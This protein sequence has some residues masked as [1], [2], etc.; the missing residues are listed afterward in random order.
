MLRCP[1]ISASTNTLTPFWLSVVNQV[2]LPLC[3]VAPAI[4]ARA[5]KRCR[6][7]VAVFARPLLTAAFQT[8]AVYGDNPCAFFAYLRNPPNKAF[9]QN[10][11]VYRTEEPIERVVG[12]YPFGQLEKPFQP[13]VSYVPEFFNVIPWFRTANNGRQSYHDNVDKLVIPR[14]FHSRVGNIR[15]Y[16]N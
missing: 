16:I 5:Y 3:D 9:F 6:C 13:I 8:L 14:S 2:R 11:V 15:K 1:A 4:P 12:R 10:T 7:C